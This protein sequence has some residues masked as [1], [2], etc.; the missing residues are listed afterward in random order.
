MCCTKF[1][2]NRELLFRQI[3]I[4]NKNFCMLNNKQ[5]FVWLMSS[6]DPRVLN[7]FSKY[8]LEI[9]NKRNLMLGSTISNKNLS[10]H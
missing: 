5:K 9:Y 8:L 6:E 4:S 7:V 10:D 3:E 1:D 2:S